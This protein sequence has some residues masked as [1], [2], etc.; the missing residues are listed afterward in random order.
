VDGEHHLLPAAVV[1]EFLIETEA[2]AFPDRRRAHQCGVGHGVGEE[3]GKQ[4]RAGRRQQAEAAPDV[5]PRLVGMDQVDGAEIVEPVAFLAVDHRDIPFQA[6]GKDTRPE[7]E[8]LIDQMRM[9]TRIVLLDH[10]DHSETLHTRPGTAAEPAPDSPLPAA[11]RQGPYRG[12]PKDRFRWLLK[13]EW[14]S[15]VSATGTKV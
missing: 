9:F 6:L 8:H 15:S 5:A 12:N 1:E 2:R 4:S 11:P 7:A 10:D 14:Q 3:V 13:L